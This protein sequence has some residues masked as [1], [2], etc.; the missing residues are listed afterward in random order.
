MGQ[1]NRGHRH[2]DHQAHAIHL[3]KWDRELTDRERDLLKVHP[4]ITYNR[5]TVKEQHRLIEAAQR[6]Y[7][8]GASWCLLQRF[9]LNPDKSFV[10]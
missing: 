9:A 10:S 5:L 2:C 3:A 4:S 8:S 1:P 7:E 6:D